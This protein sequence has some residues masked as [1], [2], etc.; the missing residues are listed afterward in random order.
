MEE[1]VIIT[2]ITVIKLTWLGNWSGKH[3]YKCFW[4]LMSQTLNGNVKNCYRKKK[5]KNNGTYNT[6][7]GQLSQE[8][9][10]GRYWSSVLI[11]HANQS[12]EYYITLIQGCIEIMSQYSIK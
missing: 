5:V 6:F 3:L 8:W 7:H 12:N 2:M 9:T 1:L 4:L 10:D 11:S